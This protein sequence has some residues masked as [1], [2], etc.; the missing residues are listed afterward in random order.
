MC[1]T[2]V[3][4]I[5]YICFDCQKEFENYLKFNGGVITSEYELKQELKTFMEMETGS[6]PSGDFQ[7]DVAQFFADNTR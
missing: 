7:I 4:D 2:H 6:Q 3:K 1:D 5:G